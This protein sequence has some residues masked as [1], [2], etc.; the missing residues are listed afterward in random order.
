MYNHAIMSI[1]TATKREAGENLQK[2]RA[3][4]KVPAVYY[5]AGKESTSITINEI[6]F[7]RLYRAQGE[8]GVFKL[9]VDGEKIDAMVYDYQLHPVSHK[10]LHVDF[11]AVD[12]NVAIEVAVPVVLFGEAPAEKS[13]I[14]TVTH[15]TQ[16]LTV[17]ALPNSIPH[18][19]QVDISTLVDLSSQITAADIT[20]PTGVTLI[21]EPETIIAVVAALRDDSDAD[22]AE[23]DI[24]M[25][26]IEASAE[27]GKAEDEEKEA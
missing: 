6:D 18:D 19:F 3:A 10:V 9:D 11:R 25:D 24:D 16:E 13:N 27:K 12:A 5:G 22:N 7:I 14:G 15:V 8:T 1:L 2:M 23:E 4:D 17:E 26:A 20:M 21:D